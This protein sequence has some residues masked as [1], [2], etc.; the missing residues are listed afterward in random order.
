MQ[1]IFLRGINEYATILYTTP[2][3]ALYTIAQPLAAA[4]QWTRGK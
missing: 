4:N 2:D 3:S 1:W